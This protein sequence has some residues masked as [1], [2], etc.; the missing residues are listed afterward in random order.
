MWPGLQLGETAIYAPTSELRH[1]CRWRFGNDQPRNTQVRQAIPIRLASF[2]NL[3][4]SYYTATSS[5]WKKKVK[6]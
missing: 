5:V 6:N 4:S 1:Q 3:I 2:F